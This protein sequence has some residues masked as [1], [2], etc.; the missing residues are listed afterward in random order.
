MIGRIERV[1]L[2]SIWKHEAHDF[3]TWL[4]ENIDLL[5]DE[6]G[7]RLSPPEREKSTGNFS[8]DLV[9]EDESGN[10]VVIENQLE[11]SDHDHLGKLITYLTAMDATT[12]IWIVADARPEHINAITWLNES[13]A[14]GFYLVKLE[15]IKI[16]DSV[17][18]PLLTLIVGPSEEARETG[19]KK[20]VLSERHAMRKKFWASL[21]EKSKAKTNLHANITP[22]LRTWLGTGA[23][24]SGLAYAYVIRE[25]ETGIELYIDR[26]SYEDN[27]KIF[28][29]FRSNK[30]KIEEQ[31][32]E[33][34]DWQ[35]L[36]DNRFKRIAKTITLGGYNDEDKWPEIQDEMINS[37]IKLE[38]AL[39]DYIKTINI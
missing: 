11:R 29:D 32:G 18:A 16:G 4:Q 21:L 8:V 28:E 35:K 20:R 38:R 12:A 1:P 37:M 26:G 13:Y 6:L 5:N 22:S 23:G 14:A 36:K 31:F 39:S 3:T 30:E 25:H 17:P 9:S 33:P 34:L 24:I 10:I 15:G 7:L 19:E 27:M 2:R